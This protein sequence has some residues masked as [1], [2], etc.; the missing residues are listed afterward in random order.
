ML[1]SR[2]RYSRH[3]RHLFLRRSILRR[4]QANSS[5]FHSATTN[6]PWSV[7]RY[8]I[9]STQ[10]QT[11]TT[12]SS[13]SWS[14]QRPESWRMSSLRQD[15]IL[16]WTIFNGSRL[17]LPP[18]VFTLYQRPST[19]LS[20]AS[21]LPFRLDLRP[22]SPLINTMVRW[23]VL[24][25]HRCTGPLIPIFRV[26]VTHCR[27]ELFPSCTLCRSRSR[28][29]TLHYFWPDAVLVLYPRTCHVPHA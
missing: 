5:R 28:L 27:W 18:L 17:R 12:V 14:I 8:R 3:R 29:W 21:L 26:Y 15:S 22:P 11:T 2:I 1:E 24:F 9:M 7:K 16:R 19:N 23:I 10:Q 6:P 20:R 4:C 25:R 13:R